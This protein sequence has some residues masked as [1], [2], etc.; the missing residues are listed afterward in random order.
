MHHP[1]SLSKGFLLIKDSL[2]DISTDFGKGLHK[3]LPEWNELILFSFMK[4]V[5]FLLLVLKW[6]LVYEQKLKTWLKMYKLYNCFKVF[7]QTNIF[8]I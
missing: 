7:F 5:W 3:F 1:Q 6:T 2:I 4:V 8:V